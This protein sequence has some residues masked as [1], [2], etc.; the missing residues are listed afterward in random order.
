MQCGNMRAGMK[1]STTQV[2]LISSDIVQHFTLCHLVL[3]VTKLKHILKSYSFLSAPDST[4]GVQ[5]YDSNESITPEVILSLQAKDMHS[6]GNQCCICLTSMHFNPSRCSFWSLK[7]IHNLYQQMKFENALKETCPNRLMNFNRQRWFVL[8][9]TMCLWLTNLSLLI[10]NESLRTIN[11]S[12]V[13]QLSEIY[14]KN[15]LEGL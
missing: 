4:H 5:G 6:Q 11:V 2:S 13:A 3:F 15:V 8:D 9:V 7:S 14:R 10:S 1:W 12:I